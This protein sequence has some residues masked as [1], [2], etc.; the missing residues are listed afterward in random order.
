V[1]Q[2]ILFGFEL[3]I[4]AHFVDAGALYHRIDPDVASALEIK[5]ILGGVQDPRVRNRARGDPAS[6]W[7]ATDSHSV[8]HL[9]NEL[10]L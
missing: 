1:L 3:P 6:S 8:A 9:K 10:T 2:K 7:L 5:Q 4:Q